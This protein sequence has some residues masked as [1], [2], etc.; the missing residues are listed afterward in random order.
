M[1]AADLIDLAGRNLRE[2][3]LR[4]ALTTA[5]ITVGVASLV[6]MLSLGI[7]LQ[8]MT[9]KWLMSSGL[10]DTVFIS[11]ADREAR[12]FARRMRPE[13]SPTG[14]A[15]PLDEP[16]R[17]EIS[18]LPGV[19]EVFPQIR[20]P[21]EVTYAGHAEFGMVAGLPSS[22]RQNEAFDDLQGH[23]FSSPQAEEAI[24]LADLAKQLDPQPASLLGREIVIGYAERQPLGSG[25]AGGFSVL[26]R[27]RK[28]RVVGVSER[29]PYSGISGMGRAGVFVPISLVESLNLVQPGDLRDFGAAPDPNGRTYTTLT[30]RLAS[31]VEVERVEQAIQKMGFS[32]VSLLDASRDLRRVFAVIDMFLGIFGS[33][34]LAVA[35]LG[36][37]N[38][39]VMAILERRR[40]IAIMKAL[41]ASDGDVKSL[42]FAEAGVMGLIGGALGVALGWII[43]RVINFGTGLY[44]QRQQL[45]R[46]DVWLVPW[47]LVGGAIVF[48]VVVTLVSG[49][50]PAA[51][52]AKL[53]PVQAL[54][55]E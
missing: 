6:A 21:T 36:I 13:P 43:G 8:A 7:G 25:G 31:P 16:A 22:A 54:K 53:D 9:S 29:E 51:R 39:L 35:S 23:F 2:S 47:W 40:E 5:G 45:P 18:R 55:Y 17:R 48:A 34:A 10:F 32:T 33:L 50:Y 27:E 30:A 11:G 28:L 44:L 1:K 37:V 49:L 42:F 15:H 3:W 19:L 20:F 14:P 12:P 26:R 41:G 24:L 38:T 52:A 4:N 46:E